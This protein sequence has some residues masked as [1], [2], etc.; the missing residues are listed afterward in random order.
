MP[1]TLPSESQLRSARPGRRS[2]RFLGAAVCVALFAVV[3]FSGSAPAATASS[4]V[5]Q[6]A[7]ARGGKA[8]TKAEFWRAQW[9]DEGAVSPGVATQATQPA[10]P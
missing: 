5:R 3:V 6:A 1:Q 4:K 10:A 8:L 9:R 7:P 2:L